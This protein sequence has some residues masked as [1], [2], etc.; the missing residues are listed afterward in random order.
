VPPIVSPEQFALAQAR[1]ERN[2]RLA[3]RNTRARYLLQGMVSCGGCGLA[4]TIRNNGRSAY[5]HCT[6]VLSEAS[7]RRG[8][9][10]PA[11]QVPTQR[12][13]DVVWE[14]LCRLLAEPAV[15]E[16]AL[17]RAP[18]GWLSGDEQRARQRD[19]RRRQAH[20][21]RQ[22]QRLVD[23][24]MMEALTLEELQAR[25]HQLEQRLADLRREQQR[26]VA[27]ATHGEQLERLVSQMDAFRMTLAAGL[28]RAT[29]DQRRTLVE[30][31]ID[32]VVVDAPGVEIRYI[33]PLTGLAQR[34]GV[35]RPRHRAGPLPSEAAA[36]SH[37]RVQT[38][39][40]SG[41]AGARARADP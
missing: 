2:R 23:A 7:R 13:E 12:L 9:P 14:D 41:H 28:E 33:I 19:V 18:Q 21:E 11:R 22:I 16:D 36:A 25:R 29:F 40:V 39:R 17:R 3:P 30:L 34:K 6:G 4:F 1:L 24:Y 20:T 15:L 5:Y 32:R 38:E 37:A 27:E 31:L 35:L 10:C 8:G 26:L